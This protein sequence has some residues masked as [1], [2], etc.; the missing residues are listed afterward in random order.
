MK[1]RSSGDTFLD[2]YSVAI[3][4][5]DQKIQNV[6]IHFRTRQIFMNICL[7]NW[8]HLNAISLSIRIS[9]PFFFQ[10]IEIKVQNERSKL[11]IRL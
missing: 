1:R 11:R 6:D 2:T 3:S 4:T 9:K 10:K 7:R 8:T 5:N